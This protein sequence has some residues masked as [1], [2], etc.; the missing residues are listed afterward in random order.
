MKV[1]R[2]LALMLF[3]ASALSAEAQAPASK[4]STTGEPGSMRGRVTAAARG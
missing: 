3:V 1:R 4:P 2:V